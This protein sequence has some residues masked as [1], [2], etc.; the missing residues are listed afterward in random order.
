MQSISLYTHWPLP[1]GASVANIYM[2]PFSRSLAVD[3]LG[4][5]DLFLNP[6][7]LWQFLDARACHE[8]FPVVDAGGG[9]RKTNGTRV[10]RFLKVDSPTLSDRSSKTSQSVISQV[11]DLV[12]I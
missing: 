12:Y 4:E 11:P 9:L 7:E 6:A 5:F 3:F 10:E 8:Q 1:L 2:H